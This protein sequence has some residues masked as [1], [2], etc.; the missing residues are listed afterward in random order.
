MTEP[1]RDY[2]QHTVVYSLFPIFLAG[3]ML[4]AGTLLRPG[5]YIGD[6]IN[7]RLATVYA[8]AHYGSWN[9][10]SPD[11]DHPNPFEA[12]TV[13]KVVVQGR[14][15]SSK[16]PLLP[17]LMTLIYLPF[18][19][20]GWTLD[21]PDT[22]KPFSIAVIFLLCQLPFAA[23][24]WAFMRLTS[25]MSP[26]PWIILGGMLVFASPLFGYAQQFSNHVPAAAA[27]CGALWCLW[28]L[29]DP[30]CPPSSG[31]KDALG[32]GFF[33]ALVFALDIPAIIYCATAGLLLIPTGKIRLLPWILVGFMP[34]FLTQEIC[35]WIISGS[36]L[37]VQ[38]RPELYQYEWSYW[39]HPLGIDALNESRLIYLF[40]ALIGRS[41][42]FFLFPVFFIGFIFPVLHLI[43]IIKKDHKKIKGD[44]FISFLLLLWGAFCVLT[45]YYTVK[46]NNYGGAAYGFRWHLASYPVL[47]LC[48]AHP[49]SRIKTWYGWLILLLLTGISCWSAW[50]CLQEPW[51]NSPN[52]AMRW[53]FGPPA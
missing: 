38:T 46:T 5:I 50:E 12:R 33:S 42:V 47:A 14:L 3:L 40:H 22:L 25:W 35:Y 39:R 37:P 2:T 21:D 30:D 32:F 26:I 53:I 52:W 11:P 20:V 4:I 7:S 28:R 44:T 23:G 49:I 24:I 15:I 51:G 43:K 10:E 48:C 16:P 27:L 17:L 36:L 45:L 13:D 31:V 34:I 9:L 8:L 19:M 18:R 6:S 29:L 1:K 41:S